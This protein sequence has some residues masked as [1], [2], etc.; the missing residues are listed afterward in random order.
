MHD[1]GP[2]APVR[3]GIGESAPAVASTSGLTARTRTA[4]ALS[5]TAL[6]CAA[7]CIAMIPFPVTVFLTGAAGLLSAVTSAV[8]Y[9]L[10]RRREPRALAVASSWI[11]AAALLVGLVVPIVTMA[12]HGVSA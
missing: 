8:G 10:V 4:A 7:A 1:V 3:S 11:G 2:A 9:A 6:V 12:L 5:I